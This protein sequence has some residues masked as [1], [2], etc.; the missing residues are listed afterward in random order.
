MSPLTVTATKEGLLEVTVL[1]MEALASSTSLK[2]LDRSM[3]VS[4]ASSITATSAMA[5]ATTGGS[6]TIW[7][8]VTVRAP[9]PEGAP[10]K[11][12]SRVPLPLTV[13][14][15]AR[16]PLSAPVMVTVGAAKDGSKPEPTPERLAGGCRTPPATDTVR[17][18][19]PVGV[20]EKATFTVP[21]ATMDAAPAR[22]PLSAPERIT[23][24]ADSTGE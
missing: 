21:S 1:I 14:V 7:F 5:L 24:G 11:A 18:P 23:A 17:F 22:V 12:T 15:P 8:T 4:A 3:M 13:A 19:V 10:A 6:S 16:V 9:V 20:P 2:T